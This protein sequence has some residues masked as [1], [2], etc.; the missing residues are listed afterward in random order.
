MSTSQRAARTL[1]RHVR[2]H[3]PARR[4]PEILVS[5]EESLVYLVPSLLDSSEAACLFAALE[6]WEGFKRESDDFGPQQRLSAYFGDAGCTFSYVG[7]V[8]RPQPWLPCLDLVK[9]RV[10]SVI[11]AAHGTACTGCLANNYEA[12]QG[13]IVW[14]G[15]E[16]RAH[17]SAKLVVSVSTGGARPFMLRHRTTHRTLRMMLPPGSALVM[18]GETQTHWEHALPLEPPAPH[19]ISLTFRSIVAGYEEEREPPH[20]P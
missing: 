11:A 3:S 6:S 13:S 4:P 10:D 19:R 16:V 8:C 12:D 15:D 5:E 9:R 18:A 17:G 1:A 2:Q 7:L 20:V 14:H